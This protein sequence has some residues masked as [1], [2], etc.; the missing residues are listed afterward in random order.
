MVSQYNE[1]TNIDIVVNTSIGINKLRVFKAEAVSAHKLINRLWDE[2]EKCGLS[3]IPVFKVPIF[4]LAVV[5]KSG[6]RDILKQ[7]LVSSNRIL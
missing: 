4:A 7:K 1:S 6:Y 3:E 2:D 5:K